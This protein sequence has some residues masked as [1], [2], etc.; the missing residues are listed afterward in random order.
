MAD[1]DST[2]EGVGLRPFANT[3]E[4]RRVLVTGHTGFKGSWLCL[5]LQMLGAEVSGLA[6]DPDTSPS[7]WDILRLPGIVDHRIDLNDAPAVNRVVAECAP[8]VIFHLAAQPLVR[9]SY[10]EPVTTFA[11]NVIGLVNLLE[12]IRK[13]TSVRVV[14]NATTDKVYAD[15]PRPEGYVETDPLGGY[16][17]YSSSKA[18]AEIVTECYRKS[19]LG[20]ANVAVATARAG[21]VIGG[22]D[23]AEDRLVPDIMRAAA[24]RQTV[25]VRYPMATRPWQHVLEP[26][27]GYLRLAQLMLQA[28]LSQHAWNFGPAADATLPVGEVVTRFHDAWPVFSV[29]QAMG[30]HF[31]EAAILRLDGRMAAEQLGWH[32]TWGTSQTIAR[33]VEWYRAFY[34]HRNVQSQSDIEAYVSSA[35]REGLSWAA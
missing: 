27:S 10:Q 24:L 6:L 14:V 2:L 23:W 31:H 30:E 4:G 19:F 33:T 28:P 29:Q 25:S 32:S 3:F 9:R 15:N 35:S 18:C 8:E 1:G 21:N 20:Q 12:A 11:T 26:L 16:D 34:E 17:P 13:V 7:H 22:G 5:W